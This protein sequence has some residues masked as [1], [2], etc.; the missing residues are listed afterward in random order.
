MSQVGIQELLEAG[1]H[2]GHQTSRWN[3]NM[4]R[5]IAGEIDGI[6][7]IDLLQTEE[8][9][10]DAR[11]FAGELTSGGGKILFVGTKKQASGVIEDWAEKAGMPYVS[12]RWLP[13]LLTN[14]NIASA[15]IKRLHELTELTE[16]GQIELLPTKERM[17]MQAELAKLE[18]ALGG[19]RDMDRVP[20]AVFIIDLKAEEIALREAT[21]LRLPVIALVDSNC[22]PGNIDYVIPGNDDA[23]RS[24]E[25]VISTIGEA[26]EQGAGAW[27]VIEEKRRA[28]EQAR[29]EKEEAEKKKREE[30]ERVRREAIEK[31][32]AEERARK[33]AE[34]QAKAE[35][36]AAKPAEKP[37]PQAV[38]D[39]PQAVPDHPQAVVPDHPQAVVPDHPQ[40]VVP[41]HP[42]AVAPDPEPA[43]EEP[44]AEE[45]A[46]DAPAD[47]EDNA[48]EPAKAE[49][50][51]TEEEAK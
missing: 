10:E 30:E 46:A 9:L 29:R 31:E 45:A 24:C 25:L 7:I 47:T 35:A 18:F 50:A 19:V 40:A 21:R 22:D 13:G 11:R 14:Y 3:P 17:N 49:A 23:I 15:R 37:H 33:R 39:H 20:D 34:D 6:H 32:Q 41:D 4:R 51:G 8:M 44:A 28:E 36:E 42:Q 27:A 1:V 48:E 5:H 38:P 2:F 16:S 26:I 12:R 43:A